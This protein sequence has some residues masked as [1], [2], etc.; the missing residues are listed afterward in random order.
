LLMLGKNCTVELHP[1]LSLLLKSSR[2][3][4]IHKHT[5]SAL[6]VELIFKALALLPIYCR[7]ELR[8][9]FSF[10]SVSLVF[11]HGV[12]LC[13][14]D[15]PGPHS[16]HKTGLPFTENHLPLPPEYRN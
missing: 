10:G 13:S 15:C 14:L 2:H 4:F 11:L 6:Q 7:A 16:V 8:H 12:S 5:S 3:L 9:S 1:W